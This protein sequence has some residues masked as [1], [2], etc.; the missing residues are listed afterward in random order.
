VK[1]TTYYGWSLLDNFEW[2]DG[3]ARRFGLVY[4][5]LLNGLKRLPKASAIWYSN[6]FLKHSK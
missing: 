6:N 4:V 5:D 2:R 3:F 1:L